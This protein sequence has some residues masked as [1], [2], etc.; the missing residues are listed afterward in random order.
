M[1]KQVVIKEFGTEF[2]LWKPTFGKRELEFGTNQ[3]KIPTK[4]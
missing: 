1:E 3:R 4:F 2:N